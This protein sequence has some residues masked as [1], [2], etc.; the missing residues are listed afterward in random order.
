M[1]VEPITNEPTP[2]SV[3]HPA[4]WPAEHRYIFEV[5]LGEQLK[6]PYTLEPVPELPRVE[7]RCL[8]APHQNVLCIGS[9]LLLRPRQQWLTPAALPA[10]PLTS[11]APQTILPSWNLGTL[12]VLFPPLTGF[13]KNGESFTFLP[14][15]LFGSV[16]FLLT[17]YEEL[18]LKQRDRY[19]RFPA[20]ESVAAKAGFLHR[21]LA[22]E[23]VA[24]LA[25]ALRTCFPGLQ[26]ARTRAQIR[27]THDVDHPYLFYRKSLAH[28]LYSS[29]KLLW[30][31]PSLPAARRLGHAA[32]RSGFNHDASADPF[33]S[34]DALMSASEKMGL[35]AEFYFMAGQPRARHQEAYDLQRPELQ[36]LLTQIHR[37]GHVIGLHSSYHSFRCPITLTRE[38][39]CLLHAAQQA[40]IRL[41]TV[42][43]RQ[44]YL[45]W[46]HPLTWQCWEQAA[47]A[48]DATLGFAEQA[49]FRCGTCREFPVFNPVSSQRLR[50]R[51]R[52]L[53][54][55]DVTLSEHMGLDR[56]ASLSLL[57]DLWGAVKNVG[58]TLE[59]LVHNCNPDGPWLVEELTHF[60]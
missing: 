59:V 35:P 8:G 45:R 44:H 29:A 27:L 33:N 10:L 4:S 48:Y 34:Y 31:Q 36:Q 52:P 1:H 38:H 18:V 37:R 12:P 15:D 19:G 55:M 49:G 41:S 53:T 50:L 9:N 42:G 24:L 25:T 57:H 40:G 16:F 21:P 14:L 28:M 17:R 51:E 60:T 43:G 46:E 13:S 23:Y 7:I 39:H 58:G 30:Q 20:H 2:L 6:L 5:T 26:P 22:D 32:L 3:R 47:L 56:S 11:F 54:V